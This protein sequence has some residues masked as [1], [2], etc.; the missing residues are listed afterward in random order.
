[1]RISGAARQR[2]NKSG[3]GKFSEAHDTRTSKERALETHRGVRVDWRRTSS[4][5][6]PTPRAFE[7]A[8]LYIR[9]ALL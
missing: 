9:Y 7:L 1:L 5:I 6:L 4:A 2:D 8:F 3:G